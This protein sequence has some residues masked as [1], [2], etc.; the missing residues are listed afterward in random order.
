[1]HFL[2]LFGLILEELFL[3]FEEEMDVSLLNPQL[4]MYLVLQEL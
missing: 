1:M 3:P 4:K 2:I